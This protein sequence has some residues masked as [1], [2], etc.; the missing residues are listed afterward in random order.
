MDRRLVLGVAPSVLRQPGQVVSSTPPPEPLE[1]DGT[2]ETPSSEEP[3]AATEGELD[4]ILE[5]IS[6]DG[7][8]SLD[9]RERALLEQATRRRQEDR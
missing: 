9:D 6:L 4:R 1:P 2:F 3:A 8:D 7:I 5:K